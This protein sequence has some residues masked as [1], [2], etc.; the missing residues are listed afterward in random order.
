MVLPEGC[1]EVSVANH[2]VRL[3]FVLVFVFDLDIGEGDIGKLFT[4][5]DL[6]RFGYIGHHGLSSS[7]LV[8]N[9]ISLSIFLHIFV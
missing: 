6:E 9:V 8:V 5:S 2:A 4:G 7:P 3:L 1:C